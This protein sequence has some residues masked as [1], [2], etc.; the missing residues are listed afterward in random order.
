VPVK[1]DAILKKPSHERHI[2]QVWQYEGHVLHPTHF[3]SVIPA[4]RGVSRIANSPTKDI[5]TKDR[6]D[7][8]T[9]KV[10]LK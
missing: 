3:G 6:S 10:E 1:A 8:N 4:L 7:C 5:E 2:D 9:Q